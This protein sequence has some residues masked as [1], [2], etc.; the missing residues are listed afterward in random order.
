MRKFIGGFFHFLNVQ[1][2]LVVEF[3]GVIYAIE[4]PQKMSLTS[5]WLECDFTLACAAFTVRTNAP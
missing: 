2:V 5:L 3:Y 4:Q 1:T